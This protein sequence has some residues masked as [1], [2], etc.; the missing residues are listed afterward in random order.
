MV[1]CIVAAGD[2]RRPAGAAGHGPCPDPAS[3]PTE[4]RSPSPGHW[5]PIAKLVPVK[6]MEQRR[7]NDWLAAYGF[8]LH[9]AV[10]GA[11]FFGCVSQPSSGA[12]LRVSNKS[13]CR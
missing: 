5:G 11:V 9:V 3:R 10:V 7:W 13:L 1:E 8:A 2:A 6:G 12:W 4:A